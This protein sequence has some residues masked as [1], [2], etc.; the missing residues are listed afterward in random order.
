MGVQ[1]QDSNW[2]PIIIIIVAVLILGLGALYSA[3]QRSGLREE[4]EQTCID[5]LERSHAEYRSCI[6]VD[7]DSDGDGWVSCSALFTGNTRPTPFE[8]AV[9]ITVNDGCRNQKVL[10]VHRL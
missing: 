1:Y 5:F 9:G 10:G 3:H 6:C 8:C 2:V 4:A 7:G